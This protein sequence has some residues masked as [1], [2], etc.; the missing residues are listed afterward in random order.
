[1]SMTLLQNGPAFRKTLK[2]QAKTE[3]AKAT[4]V[5]VSTVT[6]NTHFMATVVYSILLSGKPVLVNTIGS[7]V[8]ENGTWKVAAA[9]FCGLLTTQ[10]P[11]PKVCATDSRTN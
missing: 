11:P 8:Q 5:T 3:F 1:V 7:A 9:T 2:T 10:G 6:M 4:T